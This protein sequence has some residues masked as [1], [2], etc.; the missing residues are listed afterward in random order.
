MVNG[1]KSQMEEINASVQ[2]VSNGAGQI[3]EA[4]DSID[5]V[6]RSTAQNTQTISAATEEQSASNE[7]IAAASQALANL[8]TDMQ[9]AIGQFKL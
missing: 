2:T 1:I 8:A 7:E 3:V 4:V 6:S 9:T 5:T